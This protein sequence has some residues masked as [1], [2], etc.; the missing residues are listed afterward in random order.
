M[1]RTSSPLFV[2]RHSS[3]VV[4]RLRKAFVK[5]LT[6]DDRRRTTNLRIFLLSGFFAPI[7]GLGINGNTLYVGDLAGD[8][9]SVQIGS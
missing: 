9:W 8:V 1:I 6:T 4:R 3:S 5:R 7:V 2:V